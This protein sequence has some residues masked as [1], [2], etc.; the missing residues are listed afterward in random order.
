MNV[1]DLILLG[2]EVNT[3]TMKQWRKIRSDK[4]CTVSEVKV[5]GSG[6]RLRSYSGEPIRIIASFWCWVEAPNQCRS[7]EHFFVV[8][9]RNG[10]LSC[11][12]AQKLKVIH[13][14]RNDDMNVRQ[15][16]KPQSFP[17]IPKLV[18]RLSV[19]ETVQPTRNCQ[20]QIPLAL[21]QE[22]QR[23]LDELESQGIIE[24][25]RGDVEWMSPLRSVAKAADGSGTIQRRLVV[26]LR[27]VNKAVRRFRHVMPSMENLMPKLSGAR[28]FSKLDLKHAFYHV[29]LDPRSRP[30]TS[31]MTARGP[32]QFTRMPF[33]INCAPE[34]F[35]SIMEDLLRDQDGV[36]VFLDDVLI[37]AKTEIL[38]KERTD[39][40]MKLLRDANLT[41]NEKKCE[42]GKEEINF[43]G[44]ILSGTGIRPA[45]DKIEAI[46]NF[47]R[48]NCR[49][50]VKSFLGSITYIGAAI[51]NLAEKTTPLRLLTRHDQP[52]IWTAECERAFT[53]LKREASEEI[54][55][56][57]YFDNNRLTV[58]YADASPNGLGGV[59]AQRYK[60]KGETKET[61]IACAAKSLT[62][63][64]KKYPQTQREAL[65]IVWGVERFS[66]YLIGREF[67]IVTDH[68]P[69]QYIF[70]RS[71]VTDRRSLTRAEGWALRLASYR[72][73]IEIVKSERNVADAPSR[74]CSTS[75]EAYEETQ[76]GFSIFTVELKLDSFQ[77]GSGKAR[78]TKNDI[79]STSVEDST[80]QAI[81][82]ALERD[83]WE[84]PLVKSYAK[85]KDELQSCG[86][87]IT[88]SERIVL[89]PALQKIAVDIAHLSHTGASS[90][91]RHLRA[92]FWWPT[93][94]R[95]VDYRRQT[96][97]TCTRMEREGP[98]IPL[99]P[100]EIPVWPW[101]YLA[102]D[103]YSKEQ[104]VPFKIVVLQ[105]YTSKYV[106]AA[107]VKSTDASET[108]KFLDKA[109]EDLWLPR[110]L[111]SD[112]GPPFQ[113]KE[114]SDYCQSR[115]IQLI[116]SAP[117]YP[118]ANGL[119][120]RYMRNIRRTMVGAV[121]EGAKT[122][123]ELE[124]ALEV[125]NFQY[126]R[127]PHSITQ[128][129]PFKILFKQ[130]NEDIFP[131][132]LDTEGDEEVADRVREAMRKGKLY[133]DKR[134]RAKPSDIQVG[135]EVALFNFG[136]SGLDPPWKE[137]WFRVTRREGADVYIDVNGKEF[138]RNILHVK[139][140]PLTGNEI[141]LGK[142][143]EGKG[144]TNE[145]TLKFLLFLFKIHSRRARK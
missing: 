78:I 136:Y 71:K 8:D 35:Q 41:I 66:H 51:T 135:D 63:T 91:K 132:L 108:T 130:G 44:H 82:E 131:V 13:F 42:F 2:S 120:E 116:H 65:A 87:L 85:V 96:C 84:N 118:A 134:R 99:T 52:F 20:Y 102:I 75:D 43:L 95:D 97:E 139:K 23:Q 12:T 6:E 114:F 111:I 11:H 68:A 10:L 67:V 121:I 18:V 33:G 79:E 117:G 30:L 54:K 39:Q 86:N 110:K 48:P 70:E 133:Q 73:K 46:N 138:R 115:G 106:K 14:W 142:T 49:S 34:I 89:P 36:I 123:K 93:L 47:R 31:F 19:D 92:H 107:F 140:R 76:D 143:G 141:I 27:A 127:R 129:S 80:M 26:D 32:R 15:V 88:R 122:R 83:N 144:E 145:K 128:E 24:P 59:L 37:Y 45:A 1:D 9:A 94:D 21:E 28:F 100:T 98:P 137:G 58:Y 7:H 126:N 57:G 124:K 69:L 105:D 55:T 119:I 56:R 25:A 72:F 53:E 103:F 29:V 4:T 17:A 113:G 61:T 74:L 101:T 5:G 38:L 62:E 81:R 40:T 109:F 112:N 77:Y 16:H 60:E 125:A 22:T 64:E 104:P 50:E 90:M 3:I